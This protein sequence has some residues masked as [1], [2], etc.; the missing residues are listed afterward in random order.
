M[1]Q[2]VP[3][4]VPPPPPPPAIGQRDLG[5]PTAVLWA[6]VAIIGAVSMVIANGLRIALNLRMRAF[7]HDALAGKVL[8]AS[9]VQRTLDLLRIVDRVALYGS[10]VVGIVIAGWMVARSLSS[11]FRQPA[12]RHFTPFAWWTAVALAG[13]SFVLSYAVHGINLL[14]NDLHDAVQMRNLLTAHAASRFV[15]WCLTIVIVWQATDD[16]D[17]TIPT[18]Q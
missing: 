3:T 13:C 5:R 7:D 9:T 15:F 1:Y 8:G 4:L 2:S 11:R 16:H 6:P 14:G 17:R 12:L 10:V 18:L